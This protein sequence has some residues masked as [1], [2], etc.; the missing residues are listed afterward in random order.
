[1]TPSIVAL[2]LHNTAALLAWRVAVD[3]RHTQFV[4]DDPAMREEWRKISAARSADP[5]DRKSTS[6]CGAHT[7]R[8]GCCSR[9]SD[10]SITGSLA[11]SAPRWPSSRAVGLAGPSLWH[12]LQEAGG[13][14]MDR[15]RDPALAGTTH[16][17]RCACTTPDIS[18]DVAA[19][20]R[21]A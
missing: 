21:A 5:R 19:I 16:R 6:N 3:I 15:A 12:S 2:Q 11:P 9:V 20:R 17:R 18:A 1:M 8:S 7:E 13:S 10:K 14:R 4:T